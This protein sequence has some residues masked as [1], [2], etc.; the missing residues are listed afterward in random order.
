MEPTAT[1]PPATSHWEALREHTRQEALLKRAAESFASLEKERE[2]KL[3]VV[4]S[5][6]HDSQ[7]VCLACDF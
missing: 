7:I 1:E 5:S 4:S 3:T 2:R 6:H